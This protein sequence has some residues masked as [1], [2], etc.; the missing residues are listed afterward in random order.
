MRLSRSIV[1]TLL[2]CLEAGL[3]WAKQPLLRHYTIRD[4]LASNVVYDVFQDS[5]GFIWFSTDQGVSRFD[6]TTFRNFTS[7]DGLPDNDIFGVRE[8]RWHRYWLMCFSRKPCYL[9]N[10]KVY[11]SANDP[12][13]RKLKESDVQYKDLVNGPNGNQCLIGRHVIMLDSN[14]FS[15]RLYN[16][17]AALYIHYLA[18]KG[19][20]YVNSGFGISELSSTRKQALPEG[21]YWRLIYDDKNALGFDNDRKYVDQWEFSAAGIRKVSTTPVHSRIHHFSKMPD[22]NI[23]CCTEKGMQVYETASGKLKKD[24]AL[25]DNIFPNCSLLDH[26]G[27]RWFTTIN[28]GVYLM[29]EATP[30]I[31]NT[32]S[33]LSGNNILSLYMS[34]SNRLLAG[35]DQGRLNIIAGNKI[36]HFSVVEEGQPN[37]ILF[38]RM[39]NDRTAIIACDAGL[40]SIDMKTRKPHF[41]YSGNFKAGKVCRGYCLTGSAYGLGR[42]DIATRSFND[43]FQHRITAVEEDARGVIWLGALDGLYYYKNGKGVK[44]LGNEVLEQSQISSLSLNSKGEV[45]AGTNTSGIFVIPNP[46]LP[47]EH[48]DRERGL[49]GNNCKKVLGDAE[50][51]IWVCTENGLDRL[52]PQPGGAYKIHAYTL[53]DGLSG[54]RINDIAISGNWLYLATADGIVMLNKRENANK[55]PRLYILSINGSAVNSGAGSKLLQFAYDKNDLEIAYTGVSFTG[56]HNVR[57][58]YVLKGSSGDTVFTSLSTINFSALKPGSYELL[59][60]AKNKTGPWT[61]RPASLRFRIMPPPWLDLR[62]VIPVAVLLILLTVLFYRRSV[63]KVRMR[64]EKEADNKRQLAELEMK[65]LRAQINPHFVFNALSSIQAYYSQHD[66]LKA[67]YYMT[68]FALFIRK[69]LAHSQVHWLPLTEEVQMLNTYIELEQMRFKQLFTYS[70]HIDPAINPEEMKVPAMLLQ[71]YVENA[72]NHGFRHLKNRKGILFVRFTAKDNVLHCVIEDN[73][74]GIK[75]AQLNRHAS[76]KSLGM[77]ISRQRV[78]S[79]NRLYNAEIELLVKDKQADHEGTTGTII[80]ILIPLKKQN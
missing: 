30:Y 10:D 64:T 57:Y 61:L 52:I 40:F 18:R 37:R 3:L 16:E 70:I 78:D 69:T 59:L 80:E 6:G 35:G 68:S 27:N 26:E 23:L 43:L 49:N 51:N 79:M 22:G 28:D 56:G 44:F 72:I 34:D 46:E 5:K 42:Y 8:D 33:G 39:I 76:H 41:L 48:I 54:N 66:E 14:S 4:G 13:C 7:E 38:A 73:G 55:I 63:R 60:W 24:P 21:N 58:K 25:P 9:Y 77:S 17:N 50:G 20:E 19:K 47:P 36:S 45:I 1:L 11:N 53:P 32:Q 29:L 71:P 2:F 65:A 31:I 67:N 12:F 62:N 15:I 74:V 75:Q